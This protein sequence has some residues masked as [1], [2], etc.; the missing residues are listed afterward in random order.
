MADSTNSVEKALHEASSAEAIAKEGSVSLA[1]AMTSVEN[2]MKELVQH[3]ENQ[4]GDNEADLS[5]AEPSGSQTENPLDKTVSENS[6]ADGQNSEDN[7]GFGDEDADDV[8]EDTPSPQEVFSAK[9]FNLI[10]SLQ[11]GNEEK[12][13]DWENDDDAGYLT[14]TLSETEFFD[15]E[16]VAF[17]FFEFLFPF[18]AALTHTR[19]CSC[20]CPVLTAECGEAFHGKGKEERSRRSG[21]VAGSGRCDRG[22]Q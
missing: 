9:L 16:E 4:F 21:S 10:A 6:S 19:S 7:A 20:P 22:Q 17:R 11:Q 14:I 12:V 8:A 5:T 13:D 1:E 2:G 3:L 15:F 18:T